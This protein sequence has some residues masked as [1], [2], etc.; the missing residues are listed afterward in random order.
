MQKLVIVPLSISMSTIYR[1]IES[2]EGDSFG[3]SPPTNLSHKAYVC[4]APVALFMH[5]C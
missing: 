1:E 2:F 3:R 5:G 4:T